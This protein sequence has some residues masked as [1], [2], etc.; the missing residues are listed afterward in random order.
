MK[1]NEKKKMHLTVKCERIDTCMMPS[2]SSSKC[3]KTPTLRGKNEENNTH[4]LN[5]YIYTHI[6]THKRTR[7]NERKR[8]MRQR[9]ENM[10]RN[11]S[12]EKK[13][14]MGVKKRKS[15]FLSLSLLF[16]LLFLSVIPATTT[17]FVVLDKSFHIDKFR[18]NSF[19]M[20]IVVSC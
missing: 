15:F 17:A 3:V 10:T 13:E 19:K 7:A 6:H 9:R 14:K 1:K 12:T 2:S 16:L 8:K 20:K 5:S 18:S 4:S 11:R